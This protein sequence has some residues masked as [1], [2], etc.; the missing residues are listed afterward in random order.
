MTVWHLSC[1]RSP[2]K[3]LMPPSGRRISKPSSLRS[4]GACT[5]QRTRRVT[6]NFNKQ[7]RIALCLLS[8]LVLA[9]C[10]PRIPAYYTATPEPLIYYIGAG[11]A[12]VPL[13]EPIERN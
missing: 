6:A 8:S 11:G 3:M 7:S 9:S 2:N 1:K 13:T 4:R 10:H 5:C 12:H